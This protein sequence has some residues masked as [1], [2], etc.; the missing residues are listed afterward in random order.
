MMKLA[1]QKLNHYIIPNKIPTKQFLPGKELLNAHNWLLLSFNRINK[2]RKTK[3]LKP[4]LCLFWGAIIFSLFSLF[5]FCF[6]SVMRGGSCWWGI[7]CGEI[8]ASQPDHSPC[9]FSHLLWGAKSNLHNLFSLCLF[10]HIF[11]QLLQVESNYCM[12]WFPPSFLF[13]FLQIFA[14]SGANQIS[15][16]SAA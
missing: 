10:L 11:C 14:V 3:R 7:K 5:C 4:Q 6:F 1:E 12:N 2:T 15:A 13:T 8:Y 16:H 9:P